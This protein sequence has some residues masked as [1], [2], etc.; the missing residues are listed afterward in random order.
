MISLIRLIEGG[1]A[2]LAQISKN[3]HRERAGKM[4]SIPF[5]RKS[6]REDVDS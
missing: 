5:V 3:H 2:M 6:L 1:A 4:F